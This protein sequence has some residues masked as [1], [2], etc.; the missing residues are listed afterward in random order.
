MQEDDFYADIE[1]RESF[2]ERYLGLSLKTFLFS[3]A[4]VMGAGIYMGLEEYESYLS[5]EVERLKEENAA[6]QKEYF[7]LKE[8]ERDTTED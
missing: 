7:E 6:L 3:L 5:D 2:T 4:I 8:L 1:K